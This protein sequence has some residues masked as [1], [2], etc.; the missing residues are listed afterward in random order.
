[1]ETAAVTRMTG[2]KPYLSVV[3]TARNDDH[4]GNLL[5]RMQI[6]A[7]GILAQ[8][9]KYQVPV[10]LILVDWNPPHG[11]PPL[12]E[13]LNWPEDL[14]PST[15]RVIEVPPEVH[16][17]FRHAQVLPLYQMI[18]KNVGIRRA[19]GEFVLATNI[20]ILFTDEFFQLLAARGLQ[21]G[22]MY[23][24]DRYDVASDVP[25]DAPI[26]A[27]LE[28][29]RRHLLRVNAREGTFQLTQ[30]GLPALASNDIADPESGI[31]LGAGWYS[32]ERYE[33]EYFRWVNDDALLTL[34][35]G[36]RGGCVLLLDVEPGPGVRYRPF[37]LQILDDQRTLLQEQLVERR[38]LLRL[39]LAADKASATLTL[40]VI[41]GGSKVSHD[42]RVMNFRVF[43]CCWEDEALE[44]ALAGG[45]AEQTPPLGRLARWAGSFRR[46]LPS[47]QAGRLS[48]PVPR[49]LIAS[50]EPTVEQ[51]KLSFSLRPRILKLRL[52]EWF[53]SKPPSPAP[54][55]SDEAMYVL[56]G[57]GWYPL[58]FFGGELFRWSR[59]ESEWVLYMPDCAPMTMALLLEPGPG[60]GFE[61]FH[62]QIADSTGRTV[63]TAVVDR[64]RWAYLSLP[65]R[66]GQCAVFTVR[67][68]GGGKPAPLAGEV[69]ADLC[70]RVLQC[71]W[72]QGNVAGSLQREP[73]PWREPPA[74]PSNILPPGQGLAFGSGW[75]PV[76][77][78]SGISWRRV[79]NASEIILRPPP[80]QRQIYL[81]LESTAS[82]GPVLVQICDSDDRPIDQLSVVGR[83]V[84]RLRLAFDA[85]K[86]SVLR[87]R[88]PGNSDSAAEGILFLCGVGW[89]SPSTAIPGFSAVPTGVAAGAE[90]GPRIVL[91]GSLIPPP[92]AVVSRPSGDAGAALAPDWGVWDG[93]GESPA[94][95]HTNACGDF[96]LLARNDWFDLRGYPEFDLFSMN[97][98]SVFCYSA[99]YGGVVEEVL[100]DPIR[101][102]HIEHAVGSGWTPEGQAALFARIAEKGLGWIDYRELL[103]WARQMHR[104]RL[105]MIFNRANWGLAGH[106]FPERS[107]AAKPEPTAASGRRRD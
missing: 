99:H 39:P 84:K 88:F 26:E 13:A 93:A 71:G 41:G 17:T 44:T 79:Q 65:W 57:R 60:I 76:E 102:Y 97:I 20:D 53:V 69:R 31:F 106:D 46:L 74:T 42:P 52:P 16:Q 2:P 22:K 90:K 66:P 63:S 21:Q 82:A 56:W 24:I 75:G 96:T 32:V 12:A 23:R 47:W 40:R 34:K 70:F 51:G 87:F 28:Y 30:E 67:V 29:C 61:P 9:R 100:R 95:L 62:L 33:K 98:D 25:L 91:E 78:H 18:A 64:L 4:G 104:L 6:F 1:L 50:L 14:G 59:W 7:N 83:E 77:V 101:I 27:Q 103:D 38:K 68:S 10:E 36:G 11:K 43:R 3:A 15:V 5:R 73:P 37:L 89:G 92:A 58:E 80:G 94:H 19:R 85:T 86:T 105:P 48:L 35:P 8:A 54:D 49:G 107:F 72:L 55:F 45:A 81:L